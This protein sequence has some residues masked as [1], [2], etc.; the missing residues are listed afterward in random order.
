MIAKKY[1]HRFMA[2]LMAAYSRGLHLIKVIAYSKIAKRALAIL[3]VLDL[4]ILFIAI[5]LVYLTTKYGLDEA[6]GP[7]AAD[8]VR[9]RNPLASNKHI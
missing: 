8:S 3:R 2:L 4:L 1:W 9:N 5:L 7:I 6:D